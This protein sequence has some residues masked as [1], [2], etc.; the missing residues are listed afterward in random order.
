MQFN[1]GYTM[2]NY[3]G[4]GV[5]IIRSFLVNNKTYYQ[6]AVELLD[7]AGRVIGFRATSKISDKKLN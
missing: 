4:D 3:D 6:Y 1:N 5:K 7:R 2:K